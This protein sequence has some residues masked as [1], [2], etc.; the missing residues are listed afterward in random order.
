MLE[1][2]AD[3][4]ASLIG[5]GLLTGVPDVL[6]P[7]EWQQPDDP[8][9][10]DPQIKFE[11]VEFTPQGHLLV[12]FRHG[13][14]SQFESALGVND[15]VDL[16]N[17][18]PVRKYRALLLMPQHG[19]QGRLV[20]E[21]ISGRCPVTMFLR[22]LAMAEYQAAPRAWVRLK[23]EQI[24]DRRRVRDMIRE[25][26]HVSAELSQVR[27]SMPGQKRV[28]R[29]LVTEVD[30]HLGRTNLIEEAL[31]WIDIDEDRHPEDYVLRIESIAG[32]DPEQLDEVGLRFNDATIVVVDADKKEKRINPESVRDKFT[33]PVSRDLQAD[34][35]TWVARARTVLSGTLLE[36]TDIQV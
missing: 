6:R 13:V 28:R 16:R 15:E 1:R 26:E 4:A 29:R 10:Q 22:W 21:T 19:T 3:A 9:P 2:S 30:S 24:G 36:G 14:F 20:V 32:F 18:A 17:R 8:Q 7:H 31:S 35:T 25:A 23:S 33:Y 27:P 11:N 34:N 12:E 5:Q